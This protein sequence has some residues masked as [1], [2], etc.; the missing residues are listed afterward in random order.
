MI[1]D[2]NITLA[3]GPREIGAAMQEF[4]ED[5]SRETTET[6][7]VIFMIIAT[8]WVFLLVVL[9]VSFFATVSALYPWRVHL[10]EEE[11][12]HNQQ[13]I[14]N[15]NCRVVGPREARARTIM[16]RQEKAY[17]GFMLS[18]WKPDEER[19]LP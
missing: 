6:S 7:H 15:M 4:F 13:K 10:T 5:A 17:K 8:P 2:K 16:F 9:L 18:C 14:E 19:R 3:D 11:W 1:L 12:R